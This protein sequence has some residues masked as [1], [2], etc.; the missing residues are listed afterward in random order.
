MLVLRIPDPQHWS[1]TNVDPKIDNEKCRELANP[2]TKQRDKVRA[3]LGSLDEIGGGMCHPLINIRW[4]LLPLFFCLTNP[5]LV[6]DV[7]PLNP[8]EHTLGFS[9]GFF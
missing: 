2:P 6:I 1:G 3:M 5:A 7:L 8:L 9:C 4:H